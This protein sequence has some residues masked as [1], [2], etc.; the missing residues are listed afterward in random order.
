MH[1]WALRTS[2]HEVEVLKEQLVEEEYVHLLEKEAAGMRV[3]VQLQKQKDALTQAGIKGDNLE[4]LL[5]AAEQSRKEVEK[6][7]A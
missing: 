4:L 2:R 3:K 5:V 7:L 1:G 6:A